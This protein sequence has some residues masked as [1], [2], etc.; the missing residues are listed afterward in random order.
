[1]EKVAEAGSLFFF[2]RRVPQKFHS[3]FVA[4][5]VSDDGTHTNRLARIRWGKLDKDFVAFL[6][7]DA[8][9]DQKAAFADVAA[10]AIY[11]DGLLAMHYKAQWE[12]EPETLPT[13]LHRF[14]IRQMTAVVDC[15]IGMIVP[16]YRRGKLQKCNRDIGA[17]VHRVR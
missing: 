4:F 7:F 17:S 15:H 2:F 14:L 16:L 6:E 5:T 1:M 3:I 8:G 10:A 9:K 13:P 12:I 11:D